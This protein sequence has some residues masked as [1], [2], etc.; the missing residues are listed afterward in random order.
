MGDRMAGAMLHVLPSE[1]LPG[2]QVV[3]GGGGLAGAGCCI[4]DG[5]N[6]DGG[7]GGCRTVG[8]VGGR[9]VPGDKGMS[10]GSG[11]GGGLS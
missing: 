10:M 2:G 5:G 8:I 11:G 7:G 3:G 9:T 6:R 4:G 1:H